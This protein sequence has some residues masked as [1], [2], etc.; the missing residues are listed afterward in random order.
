MKQSFLYAWCLSAAGC[1]S[2]LH[3]QSVSQFPDSGPE[4]TLDSLWAATGHMQA[5]SDAI[6]SQMGVHRF[7]DGKKSRFWFSGMGSFG[8]A[9]VRNE[10]SAFDYSAGGGALGYDYCASESGRGRLLGLSLGFMSG[11]PEHQGNGGPSRRISGRR[12]I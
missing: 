5:F 7:Q 6:D 9:S 10:H 11:T 12:Q 8:N 2:L 3:A 4:T 1:A